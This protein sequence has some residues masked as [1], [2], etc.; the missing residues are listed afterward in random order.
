[1]EEARPSS[2][3]FVTWPWPLQSQGT[4]VEA[5][6]VKDKR[7]ESG[8]F[9]HSRKYDVTNYTPEDDIPLK[10]CSFVVTGFEAGNKNGIKEYFH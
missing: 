3:V 9:I 5:V 4:L 2:Y 8:T 6:R 1:M 7:R 10:N